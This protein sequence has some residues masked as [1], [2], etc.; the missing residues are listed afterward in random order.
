MFAGL[1]GCCSVS[2]GQPLKIGKDLPNIIRPSKKLTKNIPNSE[3]GE[4]GHDPSPSLFFGTPVIFTPTQKTFRRFMKSVPQR[5]N[6]L[7]GKGKA[8][9]SEAKKRYDSEYHSTPERKQY[10]VELNKANRESPSPKGYDKSH[11]KN[12]KLVNEKASKNRARNQP[13]RSKK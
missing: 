13:G 4:R 1:E 7:A 11:T 10:R 12:G 2:K 5:R 6:K 8:R 9:A 3:R